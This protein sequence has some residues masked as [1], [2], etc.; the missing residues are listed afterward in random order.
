MRWAVKTRIARLERTA[1]ITRE[2]MYSHPPPGLFE[3]MHVS[4]ADN[5]LLD[6]ILDKGGQSTTPAER[7]ALERFAAEY[8]R[9]FDEVT[10]ATRD[11]NRRR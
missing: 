11:A 2:A 4:D 7:D 5:K 6:E 8:K 10:A 9:T 3:A 1:E